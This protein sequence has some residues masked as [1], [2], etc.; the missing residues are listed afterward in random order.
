MPF[1]CS[2]TDC[3]RKHKAKGYCG[4]HYQRHLNAGGVSADPIRVAASSKACSV[5]ACEKPLHANGLCNSH[6][7]RM[8]KFGSTELPAPANKPATKWVSRFGYCIVYL[9]S[10]PMA[11]SSGN[12]AEHR[13]VMAEHIGRSLLPNENVHHVNG[14]RLD[15]R[16]GNLELWSKSQPAGQRVDDKV[17]WAIELLKTYK[18]EALA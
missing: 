7:W 4:A 9:P 12:I 8:R 18:P 1:S 15:N 14:D 16:I 17:A 5:D 13:L 3:D 10:H 11:N 6:G 2:I